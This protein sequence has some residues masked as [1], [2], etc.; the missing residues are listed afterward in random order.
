MRTQ[1]VYT[2]FVTLVT[3]LALFALGGTSAFGASACMHS[4]QTSA[5]QPQQHE[6]GGHD[7]GGNTVPCQHQAAGGMC[8]SATLPAA[9]GTFSLIAPAGYVT[10]FIDATLPHSLDPAAVFHPPRV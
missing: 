7:Q 9:G 3:L 6:H 4:S 1:T 8:A 2:R 10:P 5:E